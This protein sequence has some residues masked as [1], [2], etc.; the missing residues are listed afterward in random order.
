MERTEPGAGW[1]ISGK[2]LVVSGPLIYLRNRQLDLTSI[3]QILGLS[4]LAR[5]V[6]YLHA[7]YI[8]T[9]AIFF[10]KLTLFSPVNLCIYNGDFKSL[11]K[12]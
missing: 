11:H 5:F 2:P 3:S 12:W 1:V 8:I 7:S 10:F 6:L 4:M 9:Y